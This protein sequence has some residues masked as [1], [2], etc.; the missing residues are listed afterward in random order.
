MK[1]FCVAA[2]HVL[3]GAWHSQISGFHST[4]NYSIGMAWNNVKENYVF[5]IKLVML[6]NFYVFFVPEQAA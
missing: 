5:S 3:S 1:E 2:V 6:K 4:Y